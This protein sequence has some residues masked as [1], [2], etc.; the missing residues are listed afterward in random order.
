MIRLLHL[1]KN[2]LGALFW[3]ILM[4]GFDDIGM[5]LLTLLSALLHELGH[6]F[7]ITFFV[8]KGFS[9]PKAVISGLRIKIDTPLSYRE[10]ILVCLFGPLANLIA[11]LIFL[12]F[13]YEFA[14]I[15]LATAVSNLLPMP[16]YDGEKILFAVLSEKCDT[17]KASRV[18]SHLTLIFSAAFLFLSLFLILKLNGGYWIFFVFFII[19]LKQI[20]FFQ[21]H[22]NNEK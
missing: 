11:F 9:F 6:I 10:E 5:T 19:T 17:E 15:N 8:N 2:L 14:I 1:L 4:L 3:I 16:D 13:F 22:T 12:P 20:L 21:K 18:T 7:A